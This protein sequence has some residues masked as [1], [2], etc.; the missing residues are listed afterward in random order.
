M[1]KVVKISFSS[2][3]EKDAAIAEFKEKVLDLTAKQ[4]VCLADLQAATIVINQ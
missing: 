1:S 3:D 4:A 2:Q